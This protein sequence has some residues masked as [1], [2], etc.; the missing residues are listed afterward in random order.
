MK[1]CSHNRAV[2]TAHRWRTRGVLLRPEGAAQERLRAEGG[3]EILRD[4]G[5]VHA[6]GLTGDADVDLLHRVDRHLVEHV[7]LGAPVEV[8]EERH[9][10]V[11]AA[12]DLLTDRDHKARGVRHRQRAQEQRA[13]Q[14]KDAGVEADRQTDGQDGRPGEP[15]VPAQETESVARVPGQRVKGRAAPDVARLFPHAQRR[16]NTT[17]RRRAR[18]PRRQ[19]GVFELPCGHL[20]VKRQLL[21]ELAVQTPRRRER[22]QPA[23]PFADRVHHLSSWLSARL[24]AAPSVLPM[25]YRGS[26]VQ[27][28]RGSAEN[29][30]PAPGRHPSVF[31]TRR[32][33]PNTSLKP[34]SSTPS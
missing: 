6:L 34:A 8:I 21:V 14:G 13:D 29:A 22:T 24:K 12:A 31:N 16:S 25:G 32:I 5:E 9:V 15:E 10:R 27:R 7:A 30:L 11:A 26:E 23:Y 33:A 3:E 17:P 20:G 18:V 2:M 28:F 4:E 19:T 1:C